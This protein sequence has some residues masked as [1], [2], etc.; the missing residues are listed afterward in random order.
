MDPEDH[1]ARQ[2]LASAYA[3]MGDHGASLKLFK[4][5]RKTF[6]GDPEYHVALG[7]VHMAMHDK[8]SAIGEMVLALEAKPD[9]QPALDGLI[10]LGVLVPIYEDPKDAASLT[11]VRADAVASYL[12]SLWDSAPR[13]ASY[14]L[15]QLV[16]HE[17][18]RRFEV[19]LAAAERAQ[20][21]GAPSGTGAEVAELARIAALRTL[22][23]LDAAVAAGEAY[24]AKAPT[25]AG[26][27]VELAKSLVASGRIEGGRAASE[28][29]LELDPSNLSALMYKFWPGD[30]NDIKKIHEA[31]PALQAFVE[32]HP[33]AAGALRILARAYLATGRTDDAFSL[34]VRALELAPEDDELRAEYWGELG[35][36]QRYAEILADACKVADIGK[37]DWKLRWNEAEAYAGMGKRMEAR[38]AFSALNFDDKLH[39]DVRKR[40]KRAVK[41]IDEAPPE[42][43]AAPGDA[44][45]K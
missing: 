12:T 41:S 33:D 25:S 26:G 23:R 5:I 3:N 28:R 1:A 4:E 2:N 34:F 20:A 14:F 10:Q 40:A 24:V 13:D 30:A 6:E 44:S 22:G 15:D 42:D 29:A 32:A 43:P 21:A 7:H 17:R 19:V 39:V 18:E 16:Y 36:Q 11:Y 35:K 37:R 31:T 8:D 27:Q 38:A 9:C 45:L